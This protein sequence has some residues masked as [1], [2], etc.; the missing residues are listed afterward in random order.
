M[1]SWNLVSQDKK[2]APESHRKEVIPGRARPGQMMQALYYDRDG[3]PVS[4]ERWRQLG[5]RP[6]YSRVGYADGIRHGRPVTVITFWSGIAGDGPDGPLIFC[7]CAGIRDPGGRR[8][9]YQRLWGWP[10]I[11]AAR[12]G[13]QAV[14]A[15]IADVAAFLAGITSQLPAPGPAARPQ[16]VPVPPGGDD[17]DDD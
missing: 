13:H 17:D 5:R 3:R 2:A 11:A 8:T 14:T 7:T 12:A 16:P 4:Q 15:W 9:V 10:N 1:D 6:G